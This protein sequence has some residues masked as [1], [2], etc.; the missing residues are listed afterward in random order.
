MII[1]I[2]PLTMN[3][4]IFFKNLTEVILIFFAIF[5]FVNPLLGQSDILRIAT[6]NILNFP[7][8]TGNDRL[9][10]F[11]KAI[12]A[13]D[14]DIVVV[15]ELL[16]E[17]G[18]QLFLSNVLNH[19]NPGLFDATPFVNGPD[20]DNGLFYKKSLINFVFSQQIS[21]ALRDISEYVLSFNDQEF[22]IYSLHLKASSGGTNEAKRLAEATILRNY[23]NTL[24][25]GS[26]F[27]VAG[28][29]NIY[30]ASEQAFIRL[31]ADQI[32]NDGKLFDP[33]DTIGNWHN[34]A[35]FASVH[36]QSPRTLQFGGGANG[37]MDD[38]FDMLLVSDSVLESGGILILK[39]SYTAFGNDGKH[40]NL[41]IVTGTNEAVPDSIADA[42]HQC[43][44]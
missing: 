37:G 10:D 36:T 20:T 33:I 23:L 22:R 35:N 11:R 21:T 40:F 2:R 38:R 29:F 18:Q 4:S 26:D 13:F 16:S 12:N 14:P 32:D 43:N 8:S 9:D 41:S 31:T 27:I 17:S 44:L 24:P 5:L 28:D 39:D 25:S 30:N 19:N 7:G 42:L 34:N 6:Y 3:R 15:Q 1:R